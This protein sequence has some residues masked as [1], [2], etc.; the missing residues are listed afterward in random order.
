MNRE[1]D[2]PSPPRFRCP[3]RDDRWRDVW[4]PNTRSLQN[5]NRNAFRKR[6]STRILSKKNTFQDSSSE[7]TDKAGWGTEGILTPRNT[8]TT[9]KGKRGS[10]NGLTRLRLRLGR[11]A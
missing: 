4:S 8:P 9:R 3:V 10:G 7:Y 11:N 5:I 2:F 1:I 6:P